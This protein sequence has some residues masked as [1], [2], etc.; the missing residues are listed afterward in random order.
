MKIVKV[1]ANL[2]NNSHQLHHR[3]STSYN[4]ENWRRP[5]LVKVGANLKKKSRQLQARPSTS[6]NI[7][8]RSRTPYERPRSGHDVKIPKK[9]KKSAAGCL[10][11]KKIRYHFQHDDSDDSVICLS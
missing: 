4:I 10:N 1:G 5:P 9:R 3:P 2:K 8:N 6:N 7:E 11:L